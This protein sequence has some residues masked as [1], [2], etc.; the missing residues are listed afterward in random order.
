MITKIF[1]QP[2]KLLVLTGIFYAIPNIERDGLT[3]WTDLS[4]VF[5][6]IPFLLILIAAFCYFDFAIRPIFHWWTLLLYASLILMVV[7]VFQKYNTF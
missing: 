1:K 5:F 4:I 3:H 2:V 7:I 6:G